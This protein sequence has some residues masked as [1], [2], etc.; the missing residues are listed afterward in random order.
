MSRTIHHRIIGTA[1]ALLNR[2]FQ[3][4]KDGHFHVVAPGEYSTVTNIRALPPAA[5]KSLRSRADKDGD[6]VIIQVVDNAAMQA[7][8]NSFPG[9]D[10]LVDYD[11]LSHDAD[12]PTRAAGWLSAPVLREGGVYAPI[13][14]TNSAQDEV[15]GGEY[16]FL[17]PEFPTGSMLEWLGDNRFRPTRL[18][19]AAVTNRPNMKTLQPLSNA[20]SDPTTTQTN[21]S[22]D[23]LK[24]IAAAL[25][26]PE[27]ATVDE[28]LAAIAEK[29][30][31]LKTLEAEV[32]ENRKAE[33]LALCEK[34]GITDEKKRTEMSD[35]YVKN[36]D[37]ARTLFGML[38][39]KKDDPRNPLTNRRNAKTPE[40]VAGDAKDK[41]EEARASRISNRA[42]ELRKN[43]P[44]LTLGQAYEQAEA[45]NPA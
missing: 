35:L 2:D 38:P 8:V 44:K 17:S 43:N 19:G 36:R 11:H 25:G 37:T 16:R 45:E 10:L 41:S 40:V 33:A 9:G 6:L 22:M 7:M 21:P 4:P 1:V 20:E 34:H 30:G 28:I 31:S 18:V 15:Q 29:T 5:Q 13:R 12:K 39:E 24:K 26:L 32:V 14:W 3:L 23:E 42:Q 27:T